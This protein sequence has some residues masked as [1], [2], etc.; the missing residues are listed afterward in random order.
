MSDSGK[1]FPPVISSRGKHLNSSEA[2]LIEI[3]EATVPVAGTSGQVLTTTG[4][5]LKWSTAGGGSGTVSNVTFT[6]DGTV[7]SSTPSTA[8]TTTGTLAGTLLT[9]TK[10]VVLAGPATGSDATP[11]FRAVAAADLPTT[12]L[13]IDSHFGVITADTQSTGTWTLNAATSDAHTI[14]LTQSITTLTITGG[15]VGQ[16]LLL[17]IIQ[18]GSGSY[19]VAWPANTKWPAGAAPTLTTTVGGIDVITLWITS[20]GHYDGF[21]VGLAMA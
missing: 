7:L 3:I 11:T 14:T 18:G 15:T 17:R 12:S 5:G 10:N 13:E 8:V 2:P 19:T 6:G 4:T 20:A 9:Q 21:V 1:P 16:K